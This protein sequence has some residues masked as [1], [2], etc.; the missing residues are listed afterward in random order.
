MNL[1]IREGD[2]AMLG[3]AGEE[4]SESM[5]SGRNRLDF[6]GLVGDA[7]P[8]GEAAGTFRSFLHHL[9][10]VHSSI[11]NAAD[12]L[13]TAAVSAEADLQETD[14]VSG[15]EFVKIEMILKTT[16]HYGYGEV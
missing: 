15:S 14:K 7:M 10:Q 11:A 1:Y 12:D 5:R 6:D 13:S 2:F 8:G 9:R 16:S 4:V 3:R